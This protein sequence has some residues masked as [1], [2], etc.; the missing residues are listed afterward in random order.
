MVLREGFWGFV[1]EGLDS[2]PID[3]FPLLSRGASG[4]KERKGTHD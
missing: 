1:I 3:Q 4:A 2:S